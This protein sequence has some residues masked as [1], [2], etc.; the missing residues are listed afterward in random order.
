MNK[1]LNNKNQGVNPMPSKKWNTGAVKRVTTLYEF[2]D[3]SN[4]NFNPYV[5]DKDGNKVE[6]QRDLCWT[7]E[8]K[9]DFIESIYNDVACGNVVLKYTDDVR[10]KES[11]ADYDII[12]GKQR[13]HTI[14]EFVNNEF[15]DKN[16]Y[17][18]RD[19]SIAAQRFFKNMSV[20][21]T[22]VFESGVS[23]K[24]VINAFLTINNKGVPVS[25]EHINFVENLKKNL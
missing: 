11:H 20:F 13:I 21:T 2:T 18:W 10:Y 23:D 6:Y 17:Y 16:G 12:D 8:N 4:F 15:P 5:I 19:F 3:K 24:D 14:I 1:V 9:Q 7:L 22:Y 25:K